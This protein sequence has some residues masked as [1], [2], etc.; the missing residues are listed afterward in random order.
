M[1]GHVG[2]PNSIHEA[3]LPPREV[4]ALYSRVPLWDPARREHY[5][6]VQLTYHLP[7]SS[8]RPDHVPL[9]DRENMVNVSPPMCWHC[10][11]EFTREWAREPCPGHP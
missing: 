3:N 7:E 2:D 11:R 4:P 10:E 8:I 6:V 1:T 9:L 5:F